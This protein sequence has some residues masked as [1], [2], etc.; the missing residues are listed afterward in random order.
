MSQGSPIVW[1]EL[2]DT[3]TAEML[4]RQSARIRNPDGKAIMFPPQELYP[5]IKSIENNCKAAK[6]NHKELRYQVKLG[7][8]NLE[9]WI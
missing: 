1:I 9:L 2:E 4:M 3:D 5:T 6:I 7:E 8:D